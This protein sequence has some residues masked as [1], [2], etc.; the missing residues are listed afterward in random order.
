MFKIR[1]HE[2][3]S[4]RVAFGGSVRH[5]ERTVIIKTREGQEFER[6]GVSLLGWQSETIDRAFRDV[7]GLVNR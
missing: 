3:G 6:L 7:V 5:V 4:R 2:S 1:R